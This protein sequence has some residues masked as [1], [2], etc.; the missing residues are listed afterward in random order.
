MLKNIKLKRL[1]SLHIVIT[2]IVQGNDIL[3]DGRLGLY[4]LLIGRHVNAALPTPDPQSKYFEE[5]FRSSVLTAA[6]GLDKGMTD[7]L[8]DILDI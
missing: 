8:L 1:R 4:L 2:K 3:E 5:A 6:S 7:D